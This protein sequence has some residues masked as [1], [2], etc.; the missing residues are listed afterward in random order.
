[1][2]AA[3]RGDATIPL[4]Q[5]GAKK[6]AGVFPIGFTPVN[7]QDRWITRVWR[8]RCNFAGAAGVHGLAW[9]QIAS[10]W[11]VLSE[12]ERMRGA[13]ALLCGGTGRFHAIVIGCRA[14]PQ[15][16]RNRTLCEAG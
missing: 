1:M 4:G 2:T 7:A 13:E 14:V 6:L 15:I 11:T 16:C 9:P 3:C 10:G 12:E 5:T 8:P